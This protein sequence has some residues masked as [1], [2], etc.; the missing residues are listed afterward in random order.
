VATKWLNEKELAAWKGLWLMQLQV[1]ARLGEDL[2]NHDLSL[3]DYLVL[4]TLSDQRDGHMRIVELGNELGWEKSRVSH[5]ISRMANRGLVEK[6]RCLTDGRGFFVVLTD[7]G[8][9][10]ARAAAPNHVKLVRKLVID[11]L[12]ES[13]LNTIC[14]VSQRVLSTISL[15]QG[16]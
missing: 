13:E 3:P 16:E 12:S 4:A 9:A 5:Q 1:E 11:Q 7:H 8:R 14:K 10:R 15:G 6:E 2:A